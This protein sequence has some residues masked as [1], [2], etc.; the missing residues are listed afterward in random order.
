M[1]FW[2]CAE[3]SSDNYAKVQNLIFQVGG[4]DLAIPRESFLKMG[5]EPSNSCK[6]TLTASDMDTSGQTSMSGSFFGDGGSQNWLL[7][8]QFMQNYYSIFDYEKKKIGL[9]PS[10]E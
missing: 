6:L 10:K 8:A 2:H 4:K 7:G 3:C 1:A 9:V 5:N